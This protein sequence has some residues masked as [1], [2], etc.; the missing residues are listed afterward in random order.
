ME[1]ALTDEQ[2]LLQQQLGIALSRLSPLARIRRHAASDAVFAEDIWLGMSEFGVPGLLIAAEHGGMGLGLLDASLVSEVLGR[3]CTPLP[4]LGPVLAAPIAIAAAGSQEQQSRMLPQM[5]AGAL[6]IGIALS[7]ALAG[8]RAGGGVT[9]RDGKLFGTSL[10]AV[11]VQGAHQVLVADGDDG[12]HLVD[13][14]APG[15]SIKPLVTV[16]KTRS[17]A[18]L[19]FDAVRAETLPGATSAVHNRI[20]SA[21]YVAIAADLLGV[22]GFMMDTAVEYA[23]VRRQFSRPIG[24]FQA[25]KHLCAEMAAELEPGR[26]LMWYA[27][28]AQDANLP[29]ATLAAM[30]AKAYMADAARIAARNSIEVHGG[31]GITDDL[32]LH[33]WFKRATFGGQVFGGATQLRELAANGQGD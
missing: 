33:Y 17:V 10:F 11:D 4:F 22:G 18:A 6:R 12:L 5:A 29:D 28:Y 19:T 31:I 27:A 30:H 16:D 23:K 26:A 21:L 32:G 14:G 13:I 15:L 24:S 1:F 8:T 2:E 3:H 7:E 9:L 25:V 20:A